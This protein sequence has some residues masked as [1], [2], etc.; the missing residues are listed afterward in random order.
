[1]FWLREENKGKEEAEV[2]GMKAK[3]LR[4]AN[5]ILT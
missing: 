2:T 3:C 1:V 4:I 5:P